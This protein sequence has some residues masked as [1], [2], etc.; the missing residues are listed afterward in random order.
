[1][2]GIEEI[3]AGIAAKRKDLED[4]ARGD[5]PIPVALEVTPGLQVVIVPPE[6]P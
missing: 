5:Q 1:M 6:E 4:V 3:I 2:P